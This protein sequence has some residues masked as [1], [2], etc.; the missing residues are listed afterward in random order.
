MFDYNYYYAK[1][2]P[3]SVSKICK[4]EFPIIHYLRRFEQVILNDSIQEIL[5]IE[6]K[7]ICFRTKSV[8]FVT[9]YLSIDMREVCRRQ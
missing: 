2:S 4:S 6:F 8:S 3:E 5:S 7:Y 9:W 1:Y